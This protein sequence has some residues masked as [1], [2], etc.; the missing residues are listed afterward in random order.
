MVKNSYKF[1]IYI[2]LHSLE[3][4][5]RNIARVGP[6]IAR[7]RGG[8]MS[9]IFGPNECNISG[10]SWKKA[11]QYYYYYLWYE[12]NGQKKTK[13]TT[14]KRKFLFDIRNADIAV[15]QTLYYVIIRNM[16]IAQFKCASLERIRR[17]MRL[18]WD[19]VVIRSHIALDFSTVAYGECDIGD[20]DGV[21]YGLILNAHHKA[22][23]A[24][25]KETKYT[26][27]FHG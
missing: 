20:T 16:R 22:P 8:G 14:V 23:C 15:C 4:N 13:S 10:I 17:V 26:L 12:E 1:N 2:I 3:W 19:T 7:I 11:M 24:Q 21:E 27:L 25:A 6:N 18:I 5:T 9:A